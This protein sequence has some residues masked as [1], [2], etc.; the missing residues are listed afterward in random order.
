MDGTQEIEER[1]SACIGRDL[2][3]RK[4]SMAPIRTVL[5]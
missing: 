3:P 4:L 2:D 5:A 1:K